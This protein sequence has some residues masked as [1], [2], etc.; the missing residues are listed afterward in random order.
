MNDPSSPKRSLVKGLTYR[1]L[2]STITVLLVYL[3][4]GDLTASGVIGLFEFTIKL[5]FYYAHERI[6][7]QIPWGKR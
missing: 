7:H 3:L 6:W 2:S 1:V 4:T 5:L